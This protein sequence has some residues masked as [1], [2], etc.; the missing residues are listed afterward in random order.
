MMEFT[1]SWWMWAVVGLALVIAEVAGPGFF[2]IFFAAGALASSG[3]TYFWP[4]APVWVQFLNFS[5]VS[6]VS[7]IVFRKP[8]M[9]RFQMDGVSKAH[10]EIVEEAAYPLEDIAAGGSGKVELRGSSWNGRNSGTKVLKKGQRCSVERL[11]G[12][13]V[14]LKAD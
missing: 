11:E 2:I 12:L 10:V 14:W 13:T 9:K 1:I 5:V 7:L 8:L 4:E 3:M 6:I